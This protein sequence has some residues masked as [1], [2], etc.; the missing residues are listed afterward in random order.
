MHLKTE[1]RNTEA[2][3]ATDKFTITVRCFDACHSL[4][5][6]LTPPQKKISEDPEDIEN[7]IDHL[8]LVDI[9]RIV[10]PTAAECTF[11]PKTHRLCNRINYGLWP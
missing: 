7:I 8:D 4:I 9:Y 6:H 10:R 2:K 11:L 5:E 1:L 3:K